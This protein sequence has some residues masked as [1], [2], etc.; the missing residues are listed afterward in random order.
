MSLRRSDDRFFGGRVVLSR[1]TPLSFH[2]FRCVD[3]GR[4]LEIGVAAGVLSAKRCLCGF[5]KR[6]SGCGRESP[7]T[8]SRL[9][10]MSDAFLSFVGTAR[11]ARPL[12]RFVARL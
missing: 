2:G 6:S 10:R 3:C 11:R 8:H 5:S 4:V 1:L 9:P 12:C 7:Q